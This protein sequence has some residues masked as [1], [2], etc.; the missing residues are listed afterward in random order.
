ML[1]SQF[2]A[3]ERQE[4]HKMKN[5]PKLYD[6]VVKSIAPAIWGHED[7]K[8]GLLLMLFGGVHKVRS[9]CL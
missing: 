1:L 7:I 9:S 8:R 3:E 5:N 2:T 6:H 4:I